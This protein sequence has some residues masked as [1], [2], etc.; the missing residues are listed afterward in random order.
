MTEIK[1]ALDRLVDKVFTYK[2]DP[3]LKRCQPKKG[4]KRRARGKQNNE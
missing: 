4:E 1:K 2:P 3:E